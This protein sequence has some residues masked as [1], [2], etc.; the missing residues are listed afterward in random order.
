[1]N[2]FQCYVVWTGRK[3]G[4]LKTLEEV[5]KSTLGYSGQ[6]FIGF[7]TLQDAK[8]AYNSSYKEALKAKNEPDLC[9]SYSLDDFM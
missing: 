8:H 2:K 5:Q 7:R 3:V 4:I 9:S 1:M 6:Q